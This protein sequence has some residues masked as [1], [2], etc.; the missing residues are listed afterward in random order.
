MNVLVLPENDKL[1]QCAD[2]PGHTDPASRVV[3]VRTHDVINR[4]VPGAWIQ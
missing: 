2:H 3:Q 4:P 1:C